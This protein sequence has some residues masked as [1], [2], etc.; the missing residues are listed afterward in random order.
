MFNKICSFENLLCSYSQARRGKRYQSKVCHFNFFLEENLLELRQEL[1]FEEYVPLP[2]SHFI[3]TDPK[4]RSVAAPNFRDRVVH[5]ALVN[6]IES[7]FEKKF[8]FDSY[9]C[10]K[11]KGTGLGLKRVKKFLKSADSVY[12]KEKDIYVLQ[13][14]IEKFFKTIDWDILIGIVQKTIRCKRTMAVITKIITTHQRYQ[15]LECNKLSSSDFSQLEL[16]FEGK[17]KEILLD[18]N[19]TVSV[20]KRRGLPI[21]NLTSQLFANIYLNEL[22]HF[23]K[24]VL[25]ERWYA[26]YMD[27]FL[28]ISSDKNRLKEDKDKISEFLEQK[29]KLKLH[30]KKLMMKNI[31]DGV[32]FIGYRIF[33]DHALIRGSTLIRMQRKFHKREKQF[34]QGFITKKQFYNSRKSQEGHLKQANTYGL[35]QKMFGETTT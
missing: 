25:R 2:Y 24:E 12:G 14:D 30:P 32:P 33:K 8:I 26:R 29:L 19:E 1:L 13:C 3:V 10:R 31:K 7:I 21:G 17:L 9:A 4:T 35:R 18:P 28:I 6:I 11:H 16:D 20:I 34:K 23:V 22:D 27:D 15:D 5:H